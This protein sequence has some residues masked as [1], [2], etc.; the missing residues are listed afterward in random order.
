MLGHNKAP[1]FRQLFSE[2]PPKWNHQEKKS[3]TLILNFKWLALDLQI[4]D[5]TWY[6][7]YYKLNMTTSLRK[8]SNFRNITFRSLKFE[9]VSTIV[10]H[11]PPNSR[12]TGVKCFAAFVMTMRPTRSLPVYIITNL[13]KDQIDR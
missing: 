5:L 9:R 12:T 11:F 10:G 3:F 7:S 6:L 2:Q 8:W 4:K 1:I 13:N